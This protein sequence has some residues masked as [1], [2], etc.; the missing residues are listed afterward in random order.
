MEVSVHTLAASRPGYN[1]GTH[2]TGAR[3]SVVGVATRYGMDG[4]EFE[5]QWGQ[6]FPYP[7]RPAPRPTQ[8]LIK[9]VPSLFSGGKA[10]GA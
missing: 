8:P 6:D 9:W 5:P 2:L 3:D 7:S 4:S 10:A 1:P